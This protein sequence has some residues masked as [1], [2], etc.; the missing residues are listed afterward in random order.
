[1]GKKNR[2]KKK[3]EKEP[4]RAEIIIA[5][6]TLYDIVN[7]LLRDENFD[8]IM[9]VESKH[10]HLQSFSDDPAKN[11]LVLTAFGLANNTSSQEEVCFDRANQPNR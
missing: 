11:V 1:M 4:L 9:K 6:S 2:R 5:P 3:N 8:L 10:R 7:S